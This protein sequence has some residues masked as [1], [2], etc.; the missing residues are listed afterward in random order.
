MRRPRLSPP[1]GRHRNQ[2]GFGSVSAAAGRGLAHGSLRTRTRP[3]TRW[4]LRGIGRDVDPWPAGDTGA[5]RVARQPGFGVTPVTVTLPGT[6]RDSPD[7]H[8]LLTWPPRPRVSDRVSSSVPIPHLGRMGGVTLC[9][10][11]PS[12]NVA[13]PC[14]LPVFVS[15]ACDTFSERSASVSHDPARRPRPA[16]RLPP[17]CSWRPSPVPDFNTAKPWASRSPVCALSASVYKPPFLPPGHEIV[18]P[19]R[20]TRSLAHLLHSG[21]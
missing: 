1:V 9:G 5:R 10:I 16:S 14:L 15:P 11:R 13:P 6:A 3:C 17:P 12:S 18:F 4:L 21:L 2:P 19:C 20:L 7:S 8:G